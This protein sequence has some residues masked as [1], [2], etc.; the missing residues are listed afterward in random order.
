[1]LGLSAPHTPA[2]LALSGAT[3]E[4]TCGQGLFPGLEGTTGAWARVLAEAK[5]LW[6]EVPPP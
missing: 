5:G 2:C 1:M 4:G 6:W 3:C